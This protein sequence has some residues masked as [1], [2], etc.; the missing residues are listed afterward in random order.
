MIYDGPS[1]NIPVAGASVWHNGFPH[2]TD[3]AGAVEAC[4]NLGCALVRAVLV[5]LIVPAGTWRYNQRLTKALCHRPL[6]S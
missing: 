4:G 3:I 2:H 6:L 1:E 5:S